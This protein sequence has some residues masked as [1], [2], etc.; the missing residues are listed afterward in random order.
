MELSQI[1]PLSQSL[2]LSLNQYHWLM[3]QYQTS[4]PSSSLSHQSRL[5]CEEVTFVFKRSHSGRHSSLSRVRV[6]TLKIHQKSLGN[7]HPTPSFSPGAETL[8]MPCWTRPQGAQNTPRNYCSRDPVSVRSQLG[9]SCVPARGGVGGF[10]SRPIWSRM[11][12]R[13]LQAIA[14]SGFILQQP[15][16]A[17]AA[18]ALSHG[19]LHAQRREQGFKDFW[20]ALRAALH[21]FYHLHSFYPKGFLPYKLFFRQRKHHPD[22]ARTVLTAMQ[23]KRHAGSCEETRDEETRDAF[24]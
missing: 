21:S 6:I 10:G 20:P 2:L 1:K 14:K 23:R 16:R 12:S 11:E 19:R 15:K 5:A 4:S 3:F 18:S 17:L 9:G 7:E 22:P 8:A 24:C 13:P